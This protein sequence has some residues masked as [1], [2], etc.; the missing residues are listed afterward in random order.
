MHPAGAHVS[1]F[2]RKYVHQ[3][4]MT[5]LSK[6]ASTPDA[7]PTDTA[8]IRGLGETLEQLHEQVAKRPQWNSEGSTAVLVHVGEDKVVIL[9]KRFCIQTCSINI[10]CLLRTTPRF[11]AATSVIHEPSCATVRGAWWS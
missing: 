9:N 7:P 8:I 10:N 4:Y 3:T 2:L 6:R 1:K 5:N 11:T